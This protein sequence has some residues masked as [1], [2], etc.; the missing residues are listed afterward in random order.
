MPK[1]SV[2]TP[3]HDP[4]FLGG[5]AASL[6]AQ[7]ER[8]FEWLILPN[9][10]ARIDGPPIPEARIIQRPVLIEP[11]GNGIGALKKECCMQA[12]GEILVEAD[13]DDELTADCLEE[14]GKAFADPTV[15]FAYSNCAELRFH[16]P[17]Q[18]SA[19]S[20]WDARP[21]NYQGRE[22]IEQ[23][24]FEPGPASVSRI[25]FA[26]NHVRA[27][28]AP[29]YF[30]VGGHDPQM[31]ILDDHDLLCRTYLA[32]RMVHIDRALYIYHGH[33]GNTCQGELNARIQA[34]TMQIYD[35]Y[36][37]RLAERWCDLNGL[38][39]IDLCGG[40]NKPPGYE[41]VDL[42]GGDITCDLDGRWDFAADGE[43]GLIRAHDALEHLRDP[44]NTMREAH[45]VLAPKGWFLTQTPSTDG[46]GAWQD[47]THV[48]F[49]NSN[50][51]WY[52]TKREQAG[53]IGTPARF[54]AT[55][56]KNFFPNDFC[57]THNIVYVKA[58]LHKFDGRTPGPVEI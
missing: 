20:G 17:S 12:A 43:I 40:F 30:S 33:G 24:A 11:H 52:Y 7:T 41:S 55:R 27:W 4:R 34:E 32:G 18:Y 38:R 58:D 25:W 57:K 13:H 21:F 9:G 10:G 6:A 39:K 8:D 5:L 42:A 31:D 49:W 56:L 19:N 2:F 46:R 48:S 22:L 45:R 37:Y 36:I 23:I 50:S 1:F 53:F 51:F 3:T 14:L 54:Q 15:D 29:F 47:P 26:P 44:R 35:R 16:K 28:R